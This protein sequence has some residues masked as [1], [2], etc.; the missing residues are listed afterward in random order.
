V[1]YSTNF[2]VDIE[3]HTNPPRVTVTGATI[4]DEGELLHP[5]NADLI[6]RTVV[7]TQHDAMATAALPTGIDRWH[8]N[9]PVGT[10][11]FDLSP[12]AD[13]TAVGIEVYVL[14][15][16]VNPGSPHTTVTVTWEQAV[17]IV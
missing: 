12:G 6:S 4:V 10:R 11:P 17:T 1:A 8:G 15:P 2:E 5:D 9:V 7:L 13:V 16:G 14:H 3:V